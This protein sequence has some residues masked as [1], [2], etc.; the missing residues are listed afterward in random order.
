MESKAKLFGHPIHQMLIVFPLGLLA[1]SVI[2]DIIYLGTGNGYWAGI[3]YWMMAAGLIGGLVAAVFGFIDWLAIPEKT[4][5]KSIGAVH[6][7]GNLL[8]VLLFAGS[9]WLRTDN[10]NNPQ[11]LPLVLSFSGCVLSSVTAW[12]GGELVVRL[13]VGVDRGANLNAPN[14]IAHPSPMKTTSYN[15]EKTPPTRHAA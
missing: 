5:A 15:Q 13:G 3:S 14:S 8:V 9:W 4:R 6:G 11:T 12:L 10:P 1:T 7:L 2:F